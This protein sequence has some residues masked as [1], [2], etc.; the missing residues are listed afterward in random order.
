MKV[1]AVAGASG[2]GKTWVTERLVE[3]LR[4]LK[5]VV[6]PLDAYYHGCTETEAPTYDFDRPEAVDL[7]LLVQ[8][9]DD[10]RRGASIRRPVYDFATHRR[11]GEVEVGG[12][13]DL[14]VVE[15]LFALHDA[16]LRASCDVLAFVDERESVCLKQRILRDVSERGRSYTDALDHLEA[17]NRGLDLYVAPSRAHAELVG[18]SVNVA[19]WLVRTIL[20][21][22]G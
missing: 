5:V 1:V 8:H 11:T 17:I 10:L 9:L 15:G 4:D 20:G 2:A 21:G 14:V 19:S 6:L 13:A 18:S 16:A 3:V 7:S 22:G 12:D